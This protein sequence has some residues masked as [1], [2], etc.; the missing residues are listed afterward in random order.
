MFF[1]HIEHSYETITWAVVGEGLL[2]A[3]VEIAWILPFMFAAFLCIGLLE[4]GAGRGM[5][6]LILAA[7]KIGPLAG[8]ILGVLP[9]CGFSAAAS[10]LYSAGLLTT[11]TLLSVYISTSDEMLAILVGE[12]Q[13]PSLIFKILAIKAL[14]GIFCGFLADWVARIFYRIRENRRAKNELSCD[15]EEEILDDAMECSCADP[16]CASRGNLFVGAFV[17]TLRVILFIFIISALLN[18][19]LSLVDRESIGAFLEKIPVLGCF[20]TALMGLIPNCAISV[21]LTELFLEG[22]ISPSMMLCGLMTGAGSG[23]LI[24]F[25]QNKNK[26]ENFSVVGLLLLFSLGMGS[27]CGYLFF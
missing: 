2:E 6:K 26:L 19:A 23:L 3:L 22:I 13:S 5:V 15:E 21:A 10:N 16:Y 18:I 9:S 1:S 24:L 4:R 14:S 8:G 11:G 27:L 17:R 12:N 7:D 20:I 25:G